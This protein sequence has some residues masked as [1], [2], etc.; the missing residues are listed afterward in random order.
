MKKNPIQPVLYGS[1]VVGQKGW[2]RLSI[3][4]ITIPL[5]GTRSGQLC[6]EVKGGG[7]EDMDNLD[8]SI[9]WRISCSGLLLT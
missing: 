4:L 7:L 6:L 3:E 2:K 5:K 8:V 9:S 1:K